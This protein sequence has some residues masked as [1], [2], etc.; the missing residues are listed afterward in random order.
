MY[1]EVTIF[2]CSHLRHQCSGHRFTNS[3]PRRMSLTNIQSCAQRNHI[4]ETTSKSIT[5]GVG[6]L[7][8]RGSHLPINPGA[9]ISRTPT[10]LS[11]T[12]SKESMRSDMSS[13][14]SGDISN[15]LTMISSNQTKYLN[16]NWKTSNAIC[17]PIRFAMSGSPHWPQ[18]QRCPCGKGLKHVRDLYF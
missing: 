10:N 2:P 1:N 17:N 11:V 13:V 5:P 15:P 9:N 12:V 18:S 8:S 3:G 4:G 14:T 6:G 7:R 16:R